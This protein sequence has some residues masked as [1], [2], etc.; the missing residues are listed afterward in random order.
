MK[1]TEKQI[2]LFIEKFKE[3][4][5]RNFGTVPHVFYDKTKEIPV[6]SLSKLLTLMQDIVDND[7]ILSSL[8]IKIKSKSRK[9]EVVL[10]RQCCFKIARLQGFTLDTIGKTFAVNHS[11]VLYGIRCIDNLLEV[12]DYDALH[13][14]TKIKH[15]IKKKY[16]YDGNVESNNHSRPNS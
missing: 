2:E 16:G 15:E 4:F 13:I 7:P 6:I 5:H 3:S 8:N 1:E 10:Y 12:N 14:Y 9:R 11:T